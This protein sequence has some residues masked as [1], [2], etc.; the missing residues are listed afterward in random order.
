LSS[1]EDSGADPAAWR[2]D[3]KIALVTGASRGIGRAIADELVGRGIG[4]LILAARG[5]TDL[6]AQAQRHRA[7]GVQ[8]TAVV[9]DVATPEGRAALAAA[10]S[11]AVSALRPH[12]EMLQT[13]AVD[14]MERMIAVTEVAP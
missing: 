10:V 1:R 7:A 11:A 13:S 4:H 12:V 5:A 8:A 9:A 6:H 3:G 2:L 14:L